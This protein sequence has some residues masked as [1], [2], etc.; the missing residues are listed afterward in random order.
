MSQAGIVLVSNLVSSVS[1][2]ISTRISLSMLL[3][4]LEGDCQFPIL[5]KMLSQTSRLF[6]SFFHLLMLLV[7][8]KLREKD[9]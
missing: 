4:L 8:P 6:K 7:F 5:Q 2:I 3:L 1:K 9:V